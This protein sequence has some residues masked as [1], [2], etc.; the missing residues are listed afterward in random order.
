MTRVVPAATL[1]QHL[2]REI[3][4]EDKMLQETQRQIHEFREI[5][6]HTNAE[7]RERLAAMREELDK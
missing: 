5:H 7:K 3:K 1:R 6:G 2:N 4:A